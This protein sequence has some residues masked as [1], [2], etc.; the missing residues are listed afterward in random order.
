MLMMRLN[1]IF[2]RQVSQSRDRRAMNHNI[3]EIKPPATL[4][5]QSNENSHALL[6][7][8]CFPFGI[9]ARHL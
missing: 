4:N 7:C 5:N 3:F 9:H 6:S 8:Q 2:E 1:T